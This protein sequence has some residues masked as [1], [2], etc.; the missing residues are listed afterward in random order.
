MFVFF[1]FIKIFAC[2]QTPEELFITSFS[3]RPLPQRSHLRSGQ[4]MR[5]TACCTAGGPLREGGGGPGAAT[6]ACTTSIL[7]NTN[8]AVAA[9][10]GNTETAA[11]ASS[12]RLVP[13]TL[14]A[15]AGGARP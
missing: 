4:V 8:E 2:P 13:E 9:R 11:D 7:G 5:P 1:F 12:V 6:A 14:A 15:S 3:S 10:T